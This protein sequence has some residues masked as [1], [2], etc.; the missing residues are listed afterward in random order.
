MNKVIAKME[1]A[2]TDGIGVL[3]ERRSVAVEGYADAEDAARL[4]HARTGVRHCPSLVYP[5]RD[6]FLYSPAPFWFL[7][8]PNS[9]HSP[10]ATLPS[11]ATNL[12]PNW[13]L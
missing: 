13:I 11:L 7:H 12:D 6:R 1:P 10:P 5:S 8:A 9:A 3:Y 4:T 2:V